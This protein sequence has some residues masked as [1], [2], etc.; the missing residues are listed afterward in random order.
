VRVYANKY[1]DADPIFYSV[2]DPGDPAPEGW[3]FWNEAFDKAYGPYASYEIACSNL[4]VYVESFLGEATKED[5]REE[6]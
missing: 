2:P 4:Q 1:K 3:Y 5:E 6:S